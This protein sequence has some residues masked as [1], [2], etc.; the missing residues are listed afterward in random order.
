[1]QNHI[2]VLRDRATGV[3][4]NLLADTLNQMNAL[5]PASDHFVQPETQR[6]MM[7]VSPPSEPFQPAPVRPI[8][9]R[10]QAIPVVFGK[11]YLEDEAD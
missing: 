10:A 8:Y 3:R 4:T 9:V 7:N 5:L 2:A 6:G 11:S 1:S